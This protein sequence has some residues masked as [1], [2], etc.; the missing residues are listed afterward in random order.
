MSQK[1]EVAKQ[2]AHKQGGGRVRKGIQA[3][4][5]SWDDL[6]PDTI[7]EALDH[8]AVQI[9][10][11]FIPY[12]ASGLDAREIYKGGQE[13]YRNPKDLGGYGRAGLGAL[14]FALPFVSAGQVKSGY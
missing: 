4:R 11:S 2:I 6:K 7:E 3:L 12:V 1:P 10:G 5:G 9:G 14:A 13:I 8:P